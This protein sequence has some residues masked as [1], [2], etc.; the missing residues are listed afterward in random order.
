[1]DQSE[2]V[3]THSSQLLSLHPLATLLLVTPQVPSDATTVTTTAAFRIV[4][5]VSPIGDAFPD[6]LVKLNPGYSSMTNA[7][8]L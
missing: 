5:H 6:L 4:S 7:V 3:R 2:L 1:M 8:G